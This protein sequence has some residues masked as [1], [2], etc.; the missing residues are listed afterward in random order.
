MSRKNVAKNREEIRVSQ[1]GGG[2]INKGFWVEYIPLYM[3]DYQVTQKR[4]GQSVKK[5]KKEAIHMSREF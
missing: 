1:S 3:V 4:F 5:L 2:R